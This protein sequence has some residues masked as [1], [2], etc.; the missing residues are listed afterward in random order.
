MVSPSDRNSICEAPSDT[1]TTHSMTP[2]RANSGWTFGGKCALHEDSSGA[3][4]PERP[5]VELT[6]NLLQ[7][8]VKKHVKG[9]EEGR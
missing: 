7:E 6:G 4:T 5:D 3:E 8:E 2:H 1:H 9:Y